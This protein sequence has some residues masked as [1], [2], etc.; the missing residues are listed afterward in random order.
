MASKTGRARSKSTAFPPTIIAR[1]AASAPLV[2]PDT[3]ASRWAMPSSAR[4]LL[5]ARACSGFA[6]DISIQTIPPVKAA[7][8]LSSDSNASVAYPSDSIVTITSAS[9][10]ASAAVGAVLAPASTK[11][12]ARSAL[13]FQTVRSKPAA[14]RLRDIGAPIK[15]VPIRVIFGDEVIRAVLFAGYVTEVMV[16]RISLTYAN[17]TIQKCQKGDGIG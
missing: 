4:C 15:P 16:K 13:R 8:N 5:C 9:A 1:S 11:G 7:Q 2:P 17:R 6:L 3:G 12:A 14:I 10:I